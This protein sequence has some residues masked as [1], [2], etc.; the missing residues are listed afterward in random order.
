MRAS[1]NKLAAVIA[2][3][4]VFVVA[5]TCTPAGCVLLSPL[6]PAAAA[7]PA[8]AT[9]RCCAHQSHNDSPNPSHGGPK[10]SCPACHQPL[11]TSSSM[12]KSVGQLP[13]SLATI[14]VVPFLSPTSC[15][16]VIAHTHLLRPGFDR[17]PPLAPA[18]LLDLRCAFL[19]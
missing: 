16:W 3:L 17:P 10:K 12:M 6:T 15:A 8:A 18:T 5:A 7:V 14:L 2:A 4:A 1:G 13:A 19:A 11:Y 9:P